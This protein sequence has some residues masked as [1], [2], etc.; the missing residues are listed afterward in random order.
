MRNSHLPSC[1]YRA[2]TESAELFYCRHTATRVSGNRVTEAICKTCSVRETPCEQPR[3]PSAQ[4]LV[5]SS[6]SLAKM[7][8][9]AAIAMAR[10]VGD[11]GRTVNE[12]ELS[13]RLEI[14]DRCDLHRGN[15]CLACGCNLARKARGRVFDCPLGKWPDL[16][17]RDA[18]ERGEVDAR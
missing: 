15:R 4:D 12:Q 17:A 5:Q 13:E 2:Q 8:W 11:R 18:N 16:S 7:S 6:P 10:F 3:S 1:S 14:C 9:N